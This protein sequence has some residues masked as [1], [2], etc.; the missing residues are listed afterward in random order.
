MGAVRMAGLPVFLIGGGTIFFA[1]FGTLA[2]MEAGLT[3]RGL[4]DQIYAAATGALL[5][6]LGLAIRWGRPSL[7]PL[8]A[9]ITF[10]NA[11]A[12]IWLGLWWASIMQLLMAL[13]ML[14]GLR[15]WWWLRRHAG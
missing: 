10:A 7:V 11:L 12:T 14:S 4:F 2:A 9:V 13:V 3:I 8:A 1:A 6:V 15:G 5:V